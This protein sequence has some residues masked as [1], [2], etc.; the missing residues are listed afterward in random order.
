M[1]TISNESTLQEDGQYGKVT[2]QQLAVI[3]FY[4]KKNA[5]EC[6]ALFALFA[7][8]S[9]SLYMSSSCK[10]F[11]LLRLDVLFL[12]SQAYCVGH[13]VDGNL[14][15]PYLLKD[16]GPIFQT[17]CG[18]ECHLQKPTLVAQ[19]IYHSDRTKYPQDLKSAMI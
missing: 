11:T 4:H 5:H 9:L 8:F 13:C 15:A 14:R 18:T 10:T 17:W 1:E 7:S 19:Q 12:T 16:A 3:H 6:R 2:R